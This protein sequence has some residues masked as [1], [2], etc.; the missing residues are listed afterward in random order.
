MING[1]EIVDAHMHLMTA[2]TNRWVKEKLAERD[3]GYRR[4][5]ALWSEGFQKKYNSELGEEND[6]PPEK[7]ARDWVEELDRHGVDKAV[8][9]SLYP[10][11]DELTEFVRADSRRFYAFAT[12]DP[13]DPNAPQLLRRRVLEEGYVGLKLYPTTMGFLPSDRVVYPVYEECR[14]LGI[15]VLFH[16]GITLQ[17]DSDLRYANPIELHP[18]LKDF[19]ELP[20]IIAHFGAGYF[21]EVL[22]LAYHVNNLYVDTCG[23]NV[24]ID[25]LPYRI[26]LSEVFE[27]SLEV[28]GPQRIIF[29]TDSRM[30]SRGYRKMVLD[31]QLS[32][33]RSLELG[34]EEISLIMGGNLLRLIEGRKT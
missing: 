6:D 10:E 27:K 29:G 13:R 21:R 1:I 24:W 20:F 5:F 25:Y 30:L 9:V 2:R 15:P 11:E 7:I 23:K 4:A 34:K 32:I 26:T 19:P 12:V 3:D 31:Q 16:L 14:S 18:V 8:F 17:Y 22:F 33:L 28:F